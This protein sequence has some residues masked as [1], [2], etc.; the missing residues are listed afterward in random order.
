MSNE[1]HM[2]MKSKAY[3]ISA[4]K[5]QVIDMEDGV[6]AGSRNPG[7]RNPGGNWRLGTGELMIDSSAPR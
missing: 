5:R 6:V 2:E 4:I 3:Q 7:G 1:N